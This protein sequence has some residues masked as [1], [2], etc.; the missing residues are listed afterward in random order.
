MNSYLQH[1]WVVLMF[2]QVED[3]YCIQEIEC[4]VADL[5]DMSTDA[6]FRQTA[7]D[8]VGISCGIHLLKTIAGFIYDNEM[9]KVDIINPLCNQSS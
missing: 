6:W 9:I 2:M 7:H 4:Q 5:D 1:Q 8:H 3:R